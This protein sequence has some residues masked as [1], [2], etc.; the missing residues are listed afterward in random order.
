MYFALFMVVIL[1]VTG[2]I[3]LLDSLVL[4]KKR[5]VGTAEPV[6]VEYAKKL[7]PRHFSGI[8]CAFFY[9]RAF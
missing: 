5:P 6:A 3:W 2:S 1:V 4:R 7:F 9:C 8:F